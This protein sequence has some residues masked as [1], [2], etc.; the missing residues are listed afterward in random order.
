MT[1]PAV[2]GTPADPERAQSPPRH[3]ARAAWRAAALA[4]LGY[5]AV[6]TVVAWPLVSG[7][8]TRMQGLGDGGGMIW[9][10][11]WLRESL[12]TGQWPFATTAMLAPVGT[13]LAFHTGAPLLALLSIP[14]QWV[15]G[16][17][18]AHNLMLLAAPLASALACYGLARSL[19]QPRVAAFVAGLAFGFAPAVIDRLAMEH[20][21][22]GFTA[23]LPLT[24]L[25]LRWALAPRRGRLAAVAP[26]LVLAGALWTDL[27]ILVFSGLVAA[28]YLAGVLWQRRGGLADV[29]GAL[30]P[31]AVTAVVLAAPLLA[32]MARVVLAGEYPETPGSGGAGRYSADLVSFLLPSPHHAWFA[33]AVAGTYERIDG[34]PQDGAATLGL[35][36][37]LLAAVGLGAAWRRPAA[38]WAALL[39]A[40][41][42]ALAVGPALWVLGRPIAP[43]DVGADGPVSPLLPFTWIQSV[44]L[45]EGLRSPVR[46]VTL[47]ALGLALLAGFAVARLTGP[48]ALAAALAMAALV[49]VESASSFWTLVPARMPDV[50]EIVADDP[51]DGLVV[52]VPLGFRSG[53]HTIGDQQGPAMVWATRHGHPIATGVGARTLTSRLEALAA[54]P[55]YRD[56]L[57]LQ[58]DPAA[59]ADPVAGRRSAEELD[60]RWVTVTGRRPAVDDYLAAIGYQPVA[61]DGDTRLHRLDGGAP[62]R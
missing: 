9:G 39:V 46:F 22:V 35:S 23:W 8:T 42:L 12:A 51:G 49:A 7:L 29:A 56:L 34:R 13:P 54:I 62:S 4:L 1:A 6:L 55:L 30:L 27:T 26:G 17:V 18:V 5:V 3:L 47:A 2:T 28:A 19:R 14:I 21:N 11:W 40:A 53:F 50:Y 52:D 43:L 58:D 25:A 61:T 16:P 59:P 31:G 37:L 32:V 24:L 60:A 41:G 36:I 57:A 10:F 38:R 20:L 44:P 33:D 45:L 15:A 48:R